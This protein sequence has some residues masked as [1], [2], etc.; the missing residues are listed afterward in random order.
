[1][2]FKLLWDR[3]IRKHNIPF[4]LKCFNL[5]DDLIGIIH[6]FG[7]IMKKTRHFGL[8]FKEKLIVW[9]AETIAFPPLFIRSNRSA[10]QIARVYTQQNI[11]CI[12]IFL[13]NIMRVI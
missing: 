12:C 13:I 9:E 10:L 4:E 3:E 5:I 2:L 7:N 6:R 11:M 1:M 8:S